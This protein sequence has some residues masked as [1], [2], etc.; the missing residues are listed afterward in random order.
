MTE[1]YGLDYCG[2]I[3]GSELLAQQ[4]KRSNLVSWVGRYFS[5][6]GDGVVTTCDK[7]NDNGAAEAAD[8]RAANIRSVVPLAN[9]GE[10]R[11]ASSNS[12]DGYNDGSWVC[13]RI[14]GQVAPSVLSLPPGGQVY[15]YLDIEHNAGIT[16]NYWNGWADGVRQYAFP[17]PSDFVFYP[18]AYVN[19]GDANGPINTVLTVGRTCWG[20]WFASYPLPAVCGTP[21]PTFR[22][23]AFSGL[24]THYWQYSQDA[25]C[26][27]VVDTDESNPTFNM[28][29]FAMKIQG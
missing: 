17:G 15:V 11:I 5:S 2:R 20:I 19:D 26:A 16:Q 7:F 12:L 29:D 28:T 24:T 10:G 14:A 18:C 25:D 13:Q 23:S 1:Q 27:D 22:S 4:A 8:L 6:R 9:P 3:S 21:G